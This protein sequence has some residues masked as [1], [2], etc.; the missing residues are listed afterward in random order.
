MYIYI[1]IYICVVLVLFC[2]GHTIGNTI[3]IVSSVHFNSI[4]ST[5]ECI[6]SS[7]SILLFDCIATVQA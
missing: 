6:S 5:L 1:Y 7:F 4:Y 2:I 3:P